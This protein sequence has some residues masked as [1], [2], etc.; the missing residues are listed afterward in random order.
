MRDIKFRAWLPDG[1]WAVAA[2]GQMVDDYAEDNLFESIGFYGDCGVI[3]MQFTGLTDKNGK[4]I[5]E[6]DYIKSGYDTTLEVYWSNKFAQ[7]RFKERGH[8][9]QECL[10]WDLEQ[11]EV[12]GNI[13]ENP[14]LMEAKP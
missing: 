4:S 1:H 14:E 12:I 7:F 13:Y 11:F 6:G 5:Y 10:F 3:F 8:G 2:C 9:N